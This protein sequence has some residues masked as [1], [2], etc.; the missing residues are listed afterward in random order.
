M[1]E[2]NNETRFGTL[3]RKLERKLNPFGKHLKVVEKDKISGM[4]TDAEN[5]DTLETIRTMQFQINNEIGFRVRQPLETITRFERSNLI[6]S[7][8]DKED[9]HSDEIFEPF[10]SKGYTVVSLK[11]YEP[12][13]DYHVYLVSWK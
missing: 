7:L 9:K 5:E 1:S 3:L 12:F 4:I 13:G 6:V 10:I 8:S 11:E 2:K